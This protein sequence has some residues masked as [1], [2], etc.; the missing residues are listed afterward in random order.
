MDGTTTFRQPGYLKAVSIIQS[1]K[2][3]IQTYACSYGIFTFKEKLGT[4]FFILYSGNSKRFFDGATG[5]RFTLQLGM[6]LLVRV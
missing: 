4:F 6:L 5:I 2:G 1:L 3:F